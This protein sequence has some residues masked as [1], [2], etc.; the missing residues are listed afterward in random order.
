MTIY[1]VRVGEETVP[2]KSVT[3]ST[4]IDIVGDALLL[5]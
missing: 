4:T 2:I 1:S 5:T 3:A